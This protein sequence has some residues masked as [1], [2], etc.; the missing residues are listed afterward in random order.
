MSTSDPLQTP[1]SH[2]FPDEWYDSAPED[3]FWMT[4]RL[5][6]ILRYLRGLKIDGCA[7]LTGFDVGCGRG[8]FQ[9]QLHSAKSWAIDGCDLNE[10]AISLNHGHNGNSILYNIFDQ[11]QD[12][13]G[14]Y[15]V[16]FLLDV[17]EH[18]AEPVAFLS[19]ARFYMKPDGYMIVNVPAVPALYSKYD[20]A[21][22]HIRRYTKNS[23]SS[24]MSAAGLVIEKIA[25]W[26][27]S[28]V[29]LLLLR[30]IASLFAKPGAIIKQGM[31]PPTVLADKLLRLMMSV[32][33]A[34]VKELPYGASLLA[35]AREA[36]R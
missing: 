5:N 29:P 2:D 31:V 20:I 15:D 32:E 6:V 8:A 36:P 33:L 16:V 22:G 3:H 27:L 23:L 30:R 26:G 17:I 35:V 12:L 28:L 18:I 4:W 11:R 7:A 19:G 25:Y 21:V 34:V 9:R 10:N 14:K 1:S 13:R 24:E